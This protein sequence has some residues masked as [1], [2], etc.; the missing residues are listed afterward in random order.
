MVSSGIDPLGGFGPMN[1]YLDTAIEHAQRNEIVV[2][3]IYMPAAG[4]AGHSF[5]RM[6]WAQNHLA[7]LTEETGGEG[8]MLGFG[9]PV[10]FAP[11]LDEIAAHLSHQYLVTFLM[12]PESKAGFRDVRFSTEVPNAEL[13]AATRV[14]VSSA[15]ERSRR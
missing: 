15:S 7:Q 6:N 2:Y 11:Y 4:H 13:V 14:Y 5:F 12:K 9:P 8:Y 10:S 1:P 3:A